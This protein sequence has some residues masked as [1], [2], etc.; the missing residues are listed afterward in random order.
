MKVK[1]M[2]TKMMLTSFVATLALGLLVTT[3]ITATTPDGITPAEETVCDVLQADGTTKGLYG[4]CVA[5][6]EATDSPENLYDDEGNTTG[7]LVP[8]EKILETYNKKAGVDDMQMPCATYYEDSECPAWTNE[9][10]YTVG[11]HVTS[12]SEGNV[13]IREDDREMWT[14]QCDGSSVLDRLWDREKVEYN[15]GTIVTSMAYLQYNT[16]SNGY[17]GNRAIYMDTTCRPDGD[18]VGTPANYTYLTDEQSNA[19]GQQIRAHKMP[20]QTP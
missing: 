19:C 6:C 13:Q 12:Q 17:E 8:S 16:E 14:T 2:K 11:T 7:L 5:Y 10:L 9:Q 1:I 20:T 18:C 15:D 4:L 3:P